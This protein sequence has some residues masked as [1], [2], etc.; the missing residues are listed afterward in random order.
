MGHEDGEVW[1][2]QRAQGIP[3]RM[4]G[5]FLRMPSSSQFPTKLTSFSP[6]SSLPPCRP[7]QTRRVGQPGAWAGVGWSAQCLLGSHVAKVG[8]QVSR[9]E[10]RL[11]GWSDPELSRNYLPVLR[12]QKG[13]GSIWSGD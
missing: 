11:A 4:P 9:Q 13:L 6:A 7:R 12:E 10:G 5:V 1:F 8:R 3:G 2:M